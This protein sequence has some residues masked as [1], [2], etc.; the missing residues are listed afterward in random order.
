[1]A[2][3]TCGLE[4]CL[5]HRSNV[6][7]GVL[8]TVLSSWD[9]YEPNVLCPSVSL[10]LLPAGSME[11]HRGSVVARQGGDILRNDGYTGPVYSELRKVLSHGTRDGSLTTPRDLAGKA[12]LA[13]GIPSDPLIAPDGLK[14]A[15]KELVPMFG[16][17]Y[18]EFPQRLVFYP[19]LPLP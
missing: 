13:D 4:V 16:G 11:L 6:K 17:T 10:H 14:L 2:E 3:I 1:M 9:V 7:Y 8:K 5:D 19:R 12:E 18:R 15:G